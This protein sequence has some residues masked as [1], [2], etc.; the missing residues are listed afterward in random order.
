MEVV[1]LD[2]LG[3]LLNSL[4]YANK[5]QYEKL[6]KTFIISNY[7]AMEVKEEKVYNV[8]M[9]ALL[10]NIGSIGI[11]EYPDEK[12]RRYRT[13]KS[14]EI[15]RIMPEI[16][17]F[18]Y[19]IADIIL[20]IDE[21]IDGSGYPAGKDNIL[22]E[23]QIV[24]LV[25]EYIKKGDI[26]KIEC[27][28][29]DIKLYETLKKL[30][31]SDGVKNIIENE[32]KLDI[33]FKKHVNSY[34]IFK[35]YIEGVEE[36]QFLSTIASLIDAKHKYTAGH[37]R[38][39]AS[40]SY[41]IAKEMRYSEEEMSHLRYSA[42]LHDIGKLAVELNIL[43]KPGKLT[44]EEFDKMKKHAEYSYRILEDSPKLKTFAEGALHHE[45]VDGKGYPFGLKG[46]D[47][48][49]VAK[50]IAIADVLDALTS[51]R[52]YRKPFTFKEAFELMEM[53]IDTAFD[54]KVFKYAK[55]CFN[56]D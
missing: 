42:Y 43:D 10:R 54:G 6:K 5:E 20:E 16:I 2:V 46:N 29:F 33:I 40:Y 14:A 21:R 23:A 30:L 7:L 44:N 31:A 32:K 1:T 49:E 27:K 36:E 38:R 26:E 15:I 34:N 48:P 39:V 37:T 12:S 47:I 8:S 11:D 3:A 19:D 53:M 35:E 24:G 22:E 41:S 28:K 56:I 9:A 51:N 25:E 50:I 52:A 55:I 18:Q 45:R 4:K 17:P 13:Y